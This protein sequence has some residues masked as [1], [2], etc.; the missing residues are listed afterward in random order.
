MSSSTTIS[1]AD[2][3]PEIAADS[4]MAFAREGRLVQGRWHGR[5]GGDDGAG[6]EIACLLGS[7]HPDINGTG[8]CPASLMPRWMAHLTVRLFDG[9]PAATVRHYGEAYAT[10]MHRWGALDGAGWERIRKAFISEVMSGAM[11]RAEELA[12]GHT[13]PLLT[14][15]R[16]VTDELLA[17]LMG[18]VATWSEYRALR[19]RAA[20]LRSKAWTEYHAARSR[21]EVAAAAAV[22]AVAVVAAVEVAAVEV[23]AAAEVA[24]VVEVAAVARRASYAR[25]FDTLLHVIDAELAA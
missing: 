19:D 18:G 11:K 20:K 22:A 12:K 1:L 4:I 16:T 8:D 23:V 9:V 15:I 10:R 6:R 25:S 24:A 13:S 3:T 17:M 14:E 21:A 5:G 2:V 7:I